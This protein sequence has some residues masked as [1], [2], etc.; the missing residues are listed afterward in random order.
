MASTPPGAEQPTMSNKRP[1]TTSLLEGKADKEDSLD[2]PISSSQDENEK[3]QPKSLKFK[4][5]VF[6]LA[7]VTVV[8][9][10]DAVIVGSALAA[11]AQDLQSSSVESFWVGTSFLLSQTV[12][13]PLYGTTSE[14]FGRKW[15]ILIAISIFLLGSILCATAQTITWLI[16]ARVVQGIGAGGMIQLVQVILSDIST[17]SERGLYM[18]IAA[19]AWSL[20]TNIGIPIGGAIGERTT[21]RWIFYINI[22]VCVICIVGLLY[23]LQ[24]QH[25]TSS[26]VKKLGMLDWAGLGVF[27]CASTLFLVG[28]TSGG[29][30]ASVGFGRCPGSWRVSKRPMMPLRI[31][32]DR[33]AIVGFVT[34]FLHG[35]VFWCLTYYMIVFFLG[36]LQHSV[37]HASLETM[38]CIA[39]SAPAGLVASM[40]VKR[41]QHFKYII[42]VGWA[43]LAAGMGTNITMH[44]DSSKAMLYGPRV[45]ISLGGGLLFPTPIF[46][47][48]ARQHGDD[49]GIATSIQVFT[50]SMGT[51]FG[52]GLGGVI[53][54][55]QWSK[56]VDSAVTAGRIPHDLIVGSNVA[57]TAYEVIRKFPEAVQ[58]AYR[59]DS[60]ATMWY[61]M[62]GLSIAGFVVSLV[63]RNDVISGG[64][65]GKQNFKDEKKGDLEGGRSG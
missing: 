8:G 21:W 37:L 52:V 56:E 9:S 18:A 24:L 45:L 36:A 27:T 64:L 30:F 15:P 51:A 23:A 38:T 20:G 53:F 60:L 32:N 29:C 46:A 25:D 42:V 17:M 41:T 13:I 4:L 54:Q 19:F 35:L 10:M 22:P 57:E 39:Y 31:F 50:R 16:G 2:R 43:L 33:S 63:G 48:Q 3:P 14:I 59:G 40:L 12:T 62:M 47:V 65:T 6:F 55:N 34:S 61:V 5:T 1:A 49:I 28:L 11:I 58:E 26:F 44:P 7:L